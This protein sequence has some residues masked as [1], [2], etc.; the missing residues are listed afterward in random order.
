[1]NA[2]QTGDQESTA[3]VGHRIVP[4][5]GFLH[6]RDVPFQ[7]VDPGERP[8]RPAPR[9]NVFGVPKIRGSCRLQSPTH[10]L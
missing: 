3:R 6:R 4:I 5:R 8:N 7:W 1:M 9:R 10:T 2:A